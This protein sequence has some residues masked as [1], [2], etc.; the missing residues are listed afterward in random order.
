[1]QCLCILGHEL[2]VFKGMNL[3]KYSPNVIVA[4]YLDLNVKRLEIKNLSIKN[5][6][7]SELY[8]FLTLIYHQKFVY[9]KSDFK[10]VSENK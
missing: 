8:N 1:M 2:N 7:N 3:Y 10:F 5:I 9:S 6:I 4:E